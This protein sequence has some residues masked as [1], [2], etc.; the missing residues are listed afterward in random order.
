VIAAAAMEI[1]VFDHL[2]IGDGNYFSFADEGYIEEYE[3][4]AIVLGNKE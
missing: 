1:R 2:I 3:K 4:Q